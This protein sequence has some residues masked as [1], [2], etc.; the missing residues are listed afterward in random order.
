MI[1]FNITIFYQF[2]NFLILLILLN[3]FLFKPVL[4]ALAKRD[5]VIRSRAEGANL[6]KDDADVL[7][8]KLLDQT[9]E[10]QKPILETKDAAIA[11]AHTQATSIIDE[12]RTELAKELTRIK[13]EIETQGKSVFEALKSDVDRL[14]RE[15]AQKV[16]KRSV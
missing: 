12:A 16:L 7:S 15:A 11:E 6:A 5:Q 3:F 2:A 8:K 4:R 9:R 13:G 14:S 10:K 1:S